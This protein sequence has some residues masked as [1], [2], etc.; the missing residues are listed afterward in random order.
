[1]KPKKLVIS[2]LSIMALIVLLSSPNRVYA[3]DRQER[4][5]FSKED[6]DASRR[7]APVNPNQVLGCSGPITK[8]VDV[9]YEDLKITS[10]VFGNNPGGGE[11]GQ[12][13]KTP[14]LSTTVTLTKKSCLN[15]HL[16]A[17]VGSKQTYSIFSPLTL[18]QVTLTP[19][20]T[21]GPRHMVGHFERPFSINSPAVGLEAERD[22]DMFA[23]NFFQKV[24]NGLHEVA[25]GTYRVD[26]WWAGAPPGPP[27]G[28]IGAAFVLK[29]YLR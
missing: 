19:A 5:M 13:D 23:A 24:G 16:S 27:G 4:P 29:L 2:F 14:V 15:A 28:A 10:A 1:M 12:F 7:A 26:V 21:A 11:G 3:Q 9:A 8:V 17:F 6:M 22:V 20:G 25:P 18:F